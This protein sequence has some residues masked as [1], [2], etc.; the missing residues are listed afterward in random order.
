[1]RFWLQKRNDI[2]TFNVRLAEPVPKRLAR[3]VDWPKSGDERTPTG[4]ARLTWFSTFS[5]EATKTDR[6][7]L[8]S[9][10]LLL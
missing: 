9:T 8:H 5:A 4:G 6:L 10:G 1:M 2:P 7:L 3:A